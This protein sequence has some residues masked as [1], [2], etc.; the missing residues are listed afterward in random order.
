MGMA[1]DGFRSRS[2][3]RT[4]SSHSHPEQRSGG[5]EPHSI[6]H[7]AP[8]SKPQPELP[9][10]AGSLGVFDKSAVADIFSESDDSRK[11]SDDYRTIQRLTSLSR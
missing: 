6:A 8:N 4:F 9:S 5:N 2:P 7:G 1:M 10:L 3:E 11:K